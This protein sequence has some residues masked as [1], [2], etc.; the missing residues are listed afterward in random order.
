[1]H[2]QHSRSVTGYE[3]LDEHGTSRIA[4]LSAGDKRYALAVDKR[5]MNR[6]LCRCRAYTYPHVFNSGLC[7]YTTATA[8]V[9]ARGLCL[10]DCP[11]YRHVVG[12]PGYCRVLSAAAE[13][14]PALAAVCRD[15]HGI[16]G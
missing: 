16:D 2:K 9:F 13:N 5:S 3:N 15:E 12:T 6:R 11:H 10:P 14:C 4:D 1:M 7:T 8:A